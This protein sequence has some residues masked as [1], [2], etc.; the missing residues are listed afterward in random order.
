ME[1]AR[2][3]ALQPRRQPSSDRYM[4]GHG[5]QLRAHSCSVRLM[6]TVRFKLLRTQGHVFSYS[7]TPPALKIG[8]DCEQYEPPISCTLLVVSTVF[9]VWWYCDTTSAKEERSV[10]RFLW[11][12]GVKTTELYEWIAIECSDNC[13]SQ[14]KVFEG[15]KKSQRRAEECW[16]G[17]LSAAINWNSVDVKE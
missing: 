5:R 3:T 12:E 9:W 4:F 8:G 7:D 1:A 15:V 11:A 13:I 17:V 6:S 16:S 2:T 10:I 14:R